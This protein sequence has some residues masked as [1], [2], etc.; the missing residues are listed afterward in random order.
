V[1]APVTPRPPAVSPAGPAAA[2]SVVVAVQIEL[3]QYDR[4]VVIK[5]PPAALKGD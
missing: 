3:S 4:P 5:A 1:Y 2:S